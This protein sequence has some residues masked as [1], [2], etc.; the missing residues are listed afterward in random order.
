MWP[1]FNRPQWWFFSVWKCEKYLCN[2][3]RFR[4]PF[5]HH[6]L[7]W[8]SKI[9][10]NA[11]TSWLIQVGSNILKFLLVLQLIAYIQLFIEVVFD[12]FFWHFIY[13]LS[14]CSINVITSPTVGNTHLQREIHNLAA[15]MWNYNPLWNSPRSPAV[16]QQRE[17]KVKVCFT[18]KTCS[19]ENNTFPC[20]L[21]SLL[22]RCIASTLFELSLRVAVLQ[23]STWV[24]TEG[25][26]HALF[27]GFIYL[28]DNSFWIRL[29]EEAELD[30]M[31]WQLII[32]W[33]SGTCL[34]ILLFAALKNHDVAAIISGG[35][36]G[37]NARPP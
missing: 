25:S 5:C 13:T 23:M 32:L 18:G 6:A 20:K 1:C 3:S 26:L 10:Q 9:T 22:V 31:V 12:H 30:R 11:S 15:V 19:G 29:A 24:W 33:F 27:W 37:E 36:G 2:Q 8:L 35:G 4:A 14:C 21:L 17:I 28:W 34:N 16:V 7:L